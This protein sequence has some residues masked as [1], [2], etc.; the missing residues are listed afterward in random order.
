[1]KRTVAILLLLCT[2]LGL[3]VSCNQEKQPPQETVTQAE[4]EVISD[5]LPN[6][7]MKNFEL[8][9]FANDSDDLSWAEITLAPEAYSGQYVYDEMYE[10]NLYIESRFNCKISVTS[11]PMMDYA[12]IEN[13]ALGDVSTDPHVVMYYDKWIMDSAMYFRNWREA[14]YVSIGEEYWNPGVS[15]LFNINGKQI[16]LSGS[17]SLGMLSRTDVIVFNKEM[18]GKYYG[19]VSSMYGFVE[20][21]EWTVEKLYELGQNVVESADDIWDEKDQ[22][23]ITGSKKEL[24]TSLLVG[25]GIRFVQKD[26]E[27]ILKFT[28]PSDTYAKDKMQKLLTLNQGNDI[29]YDNSSDVHT[30]GPENMFENGRSL[31]AVRSLFSIPNIRATMDQEFG[32]LPVPKYNSEQQE[33]YSISYGGDMA[34]LMKNVRDE[35]LEYIGIIME[36]LSFDSQQGLIPIYKERLLKTRYAS[37]PDS[38][39]M[40]DIIFTST[41]SDFGINAWE[42]TIT[43]P[44]IKQI[45]APERDVLSSVLSGMSSIHRELDNLV[46]KIR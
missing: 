28:L 23:G 32:I 30:S 11:R 43:V 10:R 36:A 44:L 41:I 8:R 4:R 27:K 13:L 46:K 19:D 7:D 9:I 39:A 35:D 22:Y 40:L 12:D 31:F 33:Y 29:Y 14:S 6:V 20:D 24:Y 25:C 34:C 45:F 18:Y 26:E 5:N 2:V 15:D 17:F 3:L 38:S 42:D 37:D 16:A 1:M 21:N